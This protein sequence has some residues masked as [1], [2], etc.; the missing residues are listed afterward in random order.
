MTRAFKTCS[1]FWLVISSWFLS[2]AVAQND[3]DAAENVDNGNSTDVPTADPTDT[4]DQSNSTEAPDEDA[5]PTSFP[6]L[7][8]FS[9]TNRSDI[10]NVHIVPHTHDDVG[11]L[12]TL[13]QYFFGTNQTIQEANVKSILDSLVVALDEARYRTFTYVEMRYF[14]MWWLDKHLD[15]SV[16]DKIESFLQSSNP[17]LS[18]VNGGW[19]MADEATTH[20]IGMIDN[21]QTG[22]HF[23]KAEFNY[24]PNIAWQIDDFGHS[25][26]QA[27]LMTSKMGMD[28]LY[29][30]R[31]DYQDLEKRKKEKETEGLW[32]GSAA[33]PDDTTVFWG[34]T[35]SYGGNYGAPKGFN[36]NTGLD[37]ADS[38]D[39]PLLQNLT[40]PERRDRI[41]NKLFPQLAEQASQT[42][43]NHIMLTMGSDFQY[44]NAPVKFESLDLM[45]EISNYLG[46]T[47]ETLVSDLFGDLGYVGVNVFYSSP[48]YYTNEKYL[49]STDEGSD[50]EYSTKTDDF[51]P[52][53]DCEHCYWTGYFVSR[54][55]FKRMER[56]ASNLLLASRQIEAIS[57][58]VEKDSDKCD[59]GWKTF[60]LEDALGVAQH[61]DAITG[62]AKQ[63]VSFDYS[64][65]LQ[66][67]IDKA[68]ELLTSLVRKLILTNHDKHNLQDLQY[69]Q[70]L[71]ETSCEVAVQQTQ[72]HGNHGLYVVVYNPL[73]QHRTHVV[74]LPVGKEGTYL[75][76]KVGEDKEARQIKSVKVAETNL[77]EGAEHVIYINTGRM[78]P[79][80]GCIFKVIGAEE[81]ED[82]NSTSSVTVSDPN[83]D[84][85]VV[86]SNGKLNV[87]FDS[88][89]GELEKV[90]VDEDDFSMAL[91]Q[92]WGYYT[93]FGSDEKGR[94][95]QNSGAYIFRPAE[96]DQELTIAAAAN[97]A[98]FVAAGDT[99]EVHVQYE[100]DWI[101][102]VTRLSA[103]QDYV[104]VEYTVG[105]IPIDDGVG[106]EIVTRFKSD[107]D[108][109]NTC[110]TDANGREFQKR[111]LNKRSS[112][113]PVAGN[114]YPVNAAIYMEDEKSSLALL[115][116]RSV[117]G[118]CLVDGSLEIMVQRRTVYDDQR[119]VGEAMNETTLGVTPYPPYGDASRQGEGIVIRGTHRIKVGKGKKGASLA[120]STMDG[121]FVEPVVFVGSAHTQKEP[122][123]RSTQFTGAKTSLPEN[124]MLIT[125]LRRSKGEYLVRL[126]HQYGIDE[127]PILSGSVEVDLADL[128][129]GFAIT[130]ILEM[131]LS[132][133]QKY[134]N[135]IDR[136]M[137]WAGSG[138]L[139]PA[140]DPDSTIVQLNPMDI[141]TILVHV[142]PATST[143]P[144]AVAPA[145]PSGTT[146]ADTT[147][148]PRPTHAP[149]TAHSRPPHVPATHSQSSSGQNDNSPSASPVLVVLGLAVVGAIAFVIYRS[150][151]YRQ[152]QEVVAFAERQYDLE[153][154]GY[155]PGLE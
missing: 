99:V 40:W 126:A 51:F 32:Q 92:T 136:R 105:P 77:A 121:T 58:S 122:D 66:H 124:V 111:I 15:E 39:D 117:G 110:Y 142:E 12:K 5:E 116:D 144:P 23:L 43:G 75:V 109:K 37:N 138:S 55:G 4:S 128:F 108:N 29:F 88:S 48:D 1:L 10:L 7:R 61:H 56:V 65:R 78:M 18:F 47:N 146:P 150:K 76:S 112:S 131:T 81:V 31:I 13:D 151:R 54:P 118:A 53:A 45:I 82:T 87:H 90:V 97:G 3:E 9:A 140:L 125:F 80:C 127:D 73:G 106:K 93:S 114:Y 107:I 22:H 34:L 8:K 42:I 153:L 63:H 60:P 83:D 59:C 96:A 50:I 152:F 94:Q 104:E 28:A 35:G 143:D 139:P 71:N 132:A 149:H 67:G 49:A 155:S 89:T 36:F 16:K 98:K 141:R 135:W 130:D 44:Q 25:S 38:K 137:D 52:Y 21:M 24:V 62:T 119:G 6:P 123:W 14:S 129:K 103:D 115:T 101:H 2:K 70:L 95:N 74:R 57:A 120:R 148:A 19:S 113:E 84:G 91:A 11:W 134:Q 86:V 64:K 17:Q 72:N 85:H 147:P 30:G 33:M 102:Q 100:E 20:F 154:S 26:T 133:N 79:L 69:C 68:S 46:A 41:A 145:T 27:S